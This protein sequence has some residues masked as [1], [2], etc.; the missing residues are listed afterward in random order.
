MSRSSVDKSKGEDRVC[1]SWR[2][3]A[4]TAVF[5]W[6]RRRRHSGGSGSRGSCLDLPESSINICH[7]CAT[8]Y[9]NPRAAEYT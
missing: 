8:C 5:Q 7:N 1:G 3:I 6:G 9:N 2:C 4:R